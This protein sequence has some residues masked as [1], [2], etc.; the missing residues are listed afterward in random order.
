MLCRYH[1]PDSFLYGVGLKYF[2]TVYQLPA[3]ITATKTQSHKEKL[4][5]MDNVY[6]ISE[7]DPNLLVDEIG[8]FRTGICAG[9][10]IGRL[11]ILPGK[12]A[13]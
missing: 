1:H 9:Y 5:D 11:W 2:E 6:Y 8:T 10:L 4:S 3:N 12:Y 13:V 7:D